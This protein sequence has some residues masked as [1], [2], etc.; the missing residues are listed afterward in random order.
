M[1]AIIALGSNL[2]DRCANIS[3]GLSALTELG[4]VTPSPHILETPDESGLG[5]DYLNTVAML[6]SA[7]EN[8][9]S[10]LEDLL[11]IE[12]RLGRERNLGRNTPR[13][14]DLDLV[15]V[16]GWV[17]QWDWPTPKD[18]T[19]VFG[20]SL[21]LELPHPR[22]SARLFVTKPLK[23]LRAKLLQDG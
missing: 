5:P 4:H 15:E 10:L 11:R 6:N 2:G 23:A 7:L 18:L 12:L 9:R 19:S 14:L 21:N 8:P 22:A 20:P 17:G 3:A 13:T 1:I 16:Q